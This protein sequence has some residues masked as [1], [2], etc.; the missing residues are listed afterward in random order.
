MAQE[1]RSA[2]PGKA[3]LTGHPDDSA[4]LRQEATRLAQLDVVKSQF[5]DLVSHE[6]RGPLGVAR[7]YVSMLADGTLGELHPRAGAVLPMVLTKLDEISRMVDQMLETARLDD[8]RLHLDRR[9]TEVRRLVGDAVALIQPKACVTGHVL[10][11]EDQAEDELCCLVDQGRMVTALANL[12][13][14]AVKYSP[15]GGEVRCT[16]VRRGDRAAVAVSDHGVGIAA[17][18]MPMLFTRFGRVG[19]TATAA[20]PGTGLGLYLSRE[21]ARRHGGDI[22]V[23]SR[24]GRGSTF[25]LSLPLEVATA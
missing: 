1:A 20:I 15:R 10:S 8:S 19:S 16:V 11:V 18:D 23:S 3:E 12:L 5:L 21:L 14:N 13:D 25:T 7:G 24:P 4:Y 6:L 9:P 2:Q 17:A 22:T